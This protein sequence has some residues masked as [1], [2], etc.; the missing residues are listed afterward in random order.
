MVGI[1]YRSGRKIKETFGKMKINFLGGGMGLEIMTSH[2]KMFSFVWRK[3]S[4]NG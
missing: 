4:I 3:G 2:I 1:Y